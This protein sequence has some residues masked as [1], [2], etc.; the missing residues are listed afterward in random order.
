M[1]V[2]QVVAECPAY[3]ALDPMLRPPGYIPNSPRIRVKRTVK[4]SED[5]LIF[6]EDIVLGV[7]EKY[8]MDG[9]MT[10][11]VNYCLDKVREL[12]AGDIPDIPIVEDGS[13]GDTVQFSITSPVVNDEFIKSIAAHYAG[14]NNEV[15]LSRVVDYCIGLVK[16][17]Y[18]ANHE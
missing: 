5:N 9:R 8:M 7:L 14:G 10:R 12:L 4:V 11:G 17:A 13:R 15:S 16:E 3:D 6:V 2:R 18:Y 1:G